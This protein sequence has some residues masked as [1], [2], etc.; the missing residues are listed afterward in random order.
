MPPPSTT[1]E[2]P[3]IHSDSSDA[4]NSA[5]LAISLGFPN[6]FID[7]VSLKDSIYSGFK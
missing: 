6:R 7:K 2:V 3:V 1:I 5:A 4:R